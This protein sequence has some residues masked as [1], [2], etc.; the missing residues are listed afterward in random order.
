MIDGALRFRMRQAEAAPCVDCGGPAPRLRFR[1]DACRAKRNAPRR[2]FGVRGGGEMYAKGGRL[3]EIEKALRAGMSIRAAARH[4]GC[5]RGTARKLYRILAAG[6]GAFQCACG[7]PSVHQGWCSAR[8]AAS[9]R[10]QAVLRA[11]RKVVA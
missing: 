11:M 5:A 10:R 9:P 3:G 2:A 1:C 4:V 8:F 6:R 7:R